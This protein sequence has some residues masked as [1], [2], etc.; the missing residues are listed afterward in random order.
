MVLITVP[1]PFV[2]CLNSLTWFFLVLFANIAFTVLSQLLFLLWV[3]MTEDQEGN[4]AFI[5]DDSEYTIASHRSR[6]PYT[7]SVNYRTDEMEEDSGT[8]DELAASAS[9]TG[10]RDQEAMKGSTSAPRPLSIKLSSAKASTAVKVETAND[11]EE[12]EEV[13]AEDPF[14]DDWDDDGKP[15]RAAPQ[16]DDV[17]LSP[18]DVHGVTD[19]NISALLGYKADERKF[20]VKWKGRSY[21]HC[22]WV[23]EDILMQQKPGRTRIKHFMKKR[24][25]YMD[26]DAELYNPNFL[27]VDRVVNELSLYDEAGDETVYYL[28]K[29]RAQPYNEATWETREDL[30][31]DDAIERYEARQI[32]PIAGVRPSCRNPR[33]KQVPKKEWEKITETPAFL[34]VHSKS[35]ELRPY[36]MEGISWLLFNWYQRRNSI[37]AD[38]MGLGKTVQSVA[39][40]EYLRLVENLSGPF[41]VV[42]P[43]STLPHWQREFDAWT[44]MN[45]LMYHGNEMARRVIN[46]NEFYF[47]SQPPANSNLP[48][49][50]F[51]FHVVCTT[52]EM[53]QR[54]NLD[55]I[56][57]QFVV[58]DEA[59]RLKNKESKLFDKLRGFNMEHLVLLTGTP[60][61]NNTVEL[62]TLLHFLEKDKFG[63]HSSFSAEFGSLQDSAQ[64]EKL[65]GMLRPYLLRRMKEDVEKALA[66][67]EE[68][69]IEVELTDVQKKWYR[70]V[71]ERNFE[72]LKVGGAKSQNLP[73][74]INIMMELRKTCNHPYLL[75]G[76]EDSI[77]GDLDHHDTSN[78][79]VNLR[80]IKS[81]GKLIL[82]DKLLPRLQ[83]HG[84]RVLIFSQMIRVL[85]ILEDYC[86]FRKYKYERLDGNIR[87]NDRQAA[88]DRYSKEGSDRFVFLLCTR[89]GGLGI[90]LTAADTVIIYDS[91][92]NPQND[93]QAQARVHRIGQTKAVK[94]YRLVTRNT[95]ERV[96]FERA[97]KKLGLDQAVL[98]SIN[99]TSKKWEGSGEGNLFEGGN[100][101]AD[102]KD[103]DKLLKYG[104]YGILHEDDESAKKFSEE[105]IDSILERR[106]IV[107][108]E[109]KGAD[110]DENA[111]NKA[112][113]VASKGADDEND[114]NVDIDDPDF[115]N[116]LL[117]DVATQSTIKE[118]E[119]TG[120][121]R[122]TRVK[123]YG[124][125]GSDSE[126]DDE[127]VEDAE[128]S[129]D[130]LQASSDPSVRG[131]RDPAIWRKNERVA[132]LNGIMR[133]GCARWEA[134]QASLP[135]RSVE[136]VQ[137]AGELL[138]KHAISMLNDDE[139]GDVRL[140]LHLHARDF[141]FDNDGEEY[142][143]TSAD[144]EPTPLAAESADGMNVSLRL[145][146]IRPD[147][148][149]HVESDRSQNKMEDRFSLEDPIINGDQKF[150]DTLDNKAMHLL[151]RVARLLCLNVLCK[152]FTSTSLPV[153]G[154]R[155]A[156]FAR[157]WNTTMDRALLCGI[158]KHGFGGQFTSLRHILADTAFGLTSKVVYIPASVSAEMEVEEREKKF[159][160]EV[161]ATNGQDASGDAADAPPLEDGAPKMTVDDLD[162]DNLHILSNLN[163]LKK[164]GNALIRQLLRFVA[165]R[166]ERMD[167]RSRRGDKEKTAEELAQERELR[168]TMPWSKRERK[169]FREKLTVVGLANPDAPDWPEFAERSGI[170]KTN[171]L[172]QR[173]YDKLLAE[174]KRSIDTWRAD[175]NNFKWRAGRKGNKKAAAG[176]KGSGNAEKEEDAPADEEEEEEEE[177][178]AGGD[179]DADAD[180]EGRD[181]EEEEEGEPTTN[182]NT[183]PSAEATEAQKKKKAGDMDVSY[184]IAKRIMERLDMYRHLDKCL[185]HDHLEMLL[186]KN[187]RRKGLPDYWSVP[188]FD[189]ALMFWVRHKG[190]GAFDAMLHQKTL[191]FYKLISE[192]QAARG[193]RNPAALEALGPAPSVEEAT[194]APTA[195]SV[196]AAAALPPPKMPEKEKPAKSGANGTEK[197]SRET[198]KLVVEQEATFILSALPPLEELLDPKHQASYRLDGNITPKD[199]IVIH[200]AE[201]LV[202]YIV[203]VGEKSVAQML[204]KAKAAEQKDALKAERAELA[205]Q[206]KA[207]RKNN[208][209]ASKKVPHG[210]FGTAPPK[211]LVVMPKDDDGNIRFPV[212]LSNALSIVDLGTVNWQLPGFHT[213]SYIYPIGF[214]SCREY[215]SDVEGTSKINYISEIL[216]INRT[217]VFRVT[218]D[219][220]NEPRVYQENSMSGAWQ[221]VVKQVNE[222]KTAETGKRQFTSV[223]G[224]EFFGIAHQNVLF[225][226]EGMEN[227]WQ[228]RDYKPRYPALQKKMVAEGILQ[229]PE[230][231]DDMEV[232][233]GTKD[234]DSDG[235]T[236]AE[237]P[238][239]PKKRSSK[240]VMDDAAAGKKQRTESPST[241]V[242]LSNPNPSAPL[243]ALKLTLKMPASA[244]GESN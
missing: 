91:D 105:S 18:Y 191:P 94:I 184:V 225:L 112:S 101:A 195:P 4:T 172:F 73:R 127:V 51:K 150:L 151:D 43:L 98:G 189:L 145:Y 34:Q 134:I 9:G 210:P 29:W 197:A 123:R 232:E 163:P 7:K 1:Q 188:D 129:D 12:E 171:E 132:L 102:R 61:Q 93:V 221:K 24:Y 33:S 58:V 65:H 76:A 136:E 79:E 180:A 217:P 146:P 19:F 8:D 166:M 57:W 194:G 233:G 142:F 69:I 13:G 10:A 155:L 36:Q 11:E 216:E 109:T 201:S 23:D 170:L 85:D 72:F 97:S 181:E 152:K 203:G 52:Y 75:T 107:M 237:V 223:S 44:G 89:A 212:Q 185:Q 62:W 20:L 46:E 90:N 74:L 238:L 239:P 206:T 243:S 228:C 100:S 196:L 164:R 128:F 37:L 135:R 82:I 215:F 32:L 6:R 31:D 153:P 174:C 179:A 162:G 200:R 229:A 222:L 208:R 183:D 35:N 213:S 198:R 110:V 88:I 95:Y 104:A 87:G 67:K 30:N 92:W 39:T 169:M 21:L 59:H 66:P 193:L 242:V 182:T 16:L 80:L 202:S 241:E 137:V 227:A 54:G 53:V 86:R 139:L 168:R 131:P 117:P 156:P 2:C 15:F 77:S 219:D 187:K 120:S 5:D 244:P 68:T 41:L 48:N 84:H 192:A 17:I 26:P 47:E 22:S 177:E 140:A 63:S 165:K 60:L 204:E 209:S 176:K 71:L 207:S 81:A 130:D 178:G 235:E 224:P 106:T 214:K 28:V 25:P 234:G 50:L 190:L 115:W 111:F 125:D 186:V 70:A 78:V 199:K 141:P 144:T 173:E 83:E 40:L 38:E 236:G 143:A 138:L 121:R 49:P 114:E 124:A 167:G 240:A 113:F 96:M 220:G 126:T 157:W 3:A 64:V 149:D 147:F 118:F 133:F 158:N 175:P 148:V 160:A 226:I 42:A 55:S 218:S 154:I 230:E 122:R 108:K 211:A 205:A 56:P 103:I 159:P 27:E 231:E 161:E 99:K 119:L 45:C 14:E 116:K